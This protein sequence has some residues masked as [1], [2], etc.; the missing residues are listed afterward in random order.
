M[1]TLGERLA[2]G[3][4]RR[5]RCAYHG[6]PEMFMYQPNRQGTAL[7]RAAYPTIYI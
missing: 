5:V 6:N 7:V 2:L 4:P 3:D 1:L